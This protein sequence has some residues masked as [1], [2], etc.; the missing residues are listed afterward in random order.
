MNPRCPDCGRVVW[1]F[2]TKRFRYFRCNFCQQEVFG[3]NIKEVVWRKREIFNG[4]GK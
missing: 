3:P 4:E 2:H 1:G